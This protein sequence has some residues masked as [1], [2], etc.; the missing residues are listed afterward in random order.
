[1]F[2]VKS[3]FTNEKK[4]TFFI[5]CLHPQIKGKQSATLQREADQREIWSIGKTLPKK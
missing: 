1:M 4:K 3:Y 2:Q 5:M